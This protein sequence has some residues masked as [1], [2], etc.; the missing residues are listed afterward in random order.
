M[1]ELANATIAR[2]VLK[3][4]FVDIFE[5]CCE[6]LARALWLVDDSAQ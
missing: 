2:L 5:F 3:M 4:C 6:R 1:A